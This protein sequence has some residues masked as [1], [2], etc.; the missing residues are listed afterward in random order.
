MAGITRVLKMWRDDDGQD[1]VEYG[2]LLSLLSIVA[3][4][5]LGGFSGPLNSMFQRAANAF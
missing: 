1:I 2:L 3:A 4:S 5:V